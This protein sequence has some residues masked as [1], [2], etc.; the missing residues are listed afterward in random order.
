MNDPRDHQQSAL[1]ER[2]RQRGAFW[3]YAPEAEI[4]DTTLIEQGLRWGEVEDIQQILSLFGKERTSAVWEQTMLPDGRIYPHNYYL[5]LIFFD[6]PDP[7]TYIR[8]RQ[9]TNSRYARI[10]KLTS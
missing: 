5:A 8:S 4:S 9:N 2:L 10:A 1:T 7:K 3:S 6:L